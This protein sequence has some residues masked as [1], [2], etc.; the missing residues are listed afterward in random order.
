MKSL[1]YILFRKFSNVGESTDFLL[2]AN[3]AK[4]LLRSIGDPLLK[5]ETRKEKINNIRNTTD[6]YLGHQI[7]RIIEL[8][9]GRLVIMICTY[10]GNCTV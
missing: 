10:L 5:V 4:L 1:A 2:K 3:D 8:E 7:Y 9:G 6:L